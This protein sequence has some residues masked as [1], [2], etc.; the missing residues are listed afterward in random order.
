[1]NI[2]IVNC[3]QHAHGDSRVSRRDC[4]VKPHFFFMFSSIFIFSTYSLLKIILK[5]LPYY[6]KFSR[7]FNFAILKKSQKSV[8]KK[9]VA[10]K[11][12][13]KFAAAKIK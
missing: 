6:M 7:H 4:Q 5:Q 1:M 9:S 10:K 8:T 12:S 11:V 2:R 3:N 13:R